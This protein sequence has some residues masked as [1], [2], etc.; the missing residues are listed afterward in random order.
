MVDASTIKWWMIQS[1]QSL[2]KDS[3]EEVMQRKLLTDN[4]SDR[5]TD[6]PDRRPYTPCQIFDSAHTDGIHHTWSFVVCIGRMLESI[7]SWL[8]VFWPS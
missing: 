3:H 6:E 7:L 5:P 1:M 2:V 8:Q 4:N